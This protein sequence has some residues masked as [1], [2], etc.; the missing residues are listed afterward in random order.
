MDGTELEGLNDRQRAFVLAY[1]KNPNGTQAVISAGYSKNGAEVTAHRLLR[2]PKIAAFLAKHRKEQQKKGFL[3]VEDMDRRLDAMT[4]ASIADA[5]YPTGQLKP[6]N[7]W[8]ESVRAAVK[9]IKSF[10]KQD[11][12]GNVVGYA[13][14]I[15]L[16]SPRGAIELGYKRRGVLKENTVTVNVEQKHDYTEEEIRIAAAL[17]H[18]K[19]KAKA[20]A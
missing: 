20:G 7:E 4:K 12:D 9:R 10:E 18:G 19:A 16:D 14:E 1:L 11:A 8:P 13:Q 5:Y 15:E 6:I 17:V 2:H 3:V